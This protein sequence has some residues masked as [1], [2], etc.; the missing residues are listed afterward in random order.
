M[1]NSI[2]TVTILGII[3]SFFPVHPMELA[4]QPFYC[5]RT[6]DLK[7]INPLSDMNKLSIY[8]NRFAVPRDT[9]LTSIPND[10]PLFAQ[11]GLALKL[12]AIKYLEK[13]DVQTL[14]VIRTAIGKGI[15]ITSEHYVT[16]NVDVKYIRIFPSP[17][18]PIS[19]F[20]S[21]KNWLKC[22]DKTP[23]VPTNGTIN[24]N[25]VSELITIIF[26]D[27]HKRQ[28]GFVRIRKEWRD[29]IRN[30]LKINIPKDLM[31]LISLYL[32]EHN[33]EKR[34]ALIKQAEQEF[35]EEQQS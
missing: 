26:R 29:Y 19:V 20:E 12:T 8:P 10:S 6:E 23:Y 7:K 16:P 21:I 1:K 30:K 5:L 14:E 24:Q 27:E 34:R 22:V 15:P 4:P 31:H 9:G 3:T 11:E 33:N 18:T 17:T 13:P 2:K 28:E 32:S 25:I 35:H